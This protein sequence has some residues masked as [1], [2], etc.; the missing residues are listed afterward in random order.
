MGANGED[1]L[2]F[3][4]SLGTGVAARLAVEL[5][6]EGVL[7]RGLV[8]SSPFESLRAVVGGYTSLSETF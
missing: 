6:K 2:I 7:F 3:G 8:L 4:H 1:I 5:G